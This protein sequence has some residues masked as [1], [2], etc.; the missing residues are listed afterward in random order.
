MVKLAMTISENLDFAIDHVFYWTDSMTVLKYIAN[1]S[2]RFHTFVANRLTVIREATKLNQWYYV[3]SKENPADCASRGIGRIDKFLS[4]TLWFNGPEFL[5]RDQHEWPKQDLHDVKE[6]KLTNDPEVKVEV[7]LAVSTLKT[8][9]SIHVD[10]IKN[11]LD[12]FSDWNKVKKITAWILH[13]KYN[14]RNLVKA[15]QTLRESMR[16]GSESEE[17]IEN[18]VKEARKKR[19]LGEKIISVLTPE[20]IKRA[21]ET[22]IIFVQRQTFSEEIYDLHIG[23]EKCVKKSSKLANLTMDF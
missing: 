18:Q 3:G 8:E 12:H 4:H 11:L 16:I 23:E 2:A 1:T 5:W 20:D 21:E 22:L 7:T 14:L 17:K 19:L 10:G 9:S 6:Q 13:A 15:T